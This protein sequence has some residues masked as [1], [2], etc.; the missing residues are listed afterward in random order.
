MV[1][2]AD[3]FTGFNE[4]VSAQL[5]SVVKLYYP[6][7]REECANCTLDTFGSV[8]RSVSI[9]KLGGPMPFDDG[10]PCP[11]CD[12][13]GYKQVEQ[14][15][16]IKGRIYSINKNFNNKSNIN[17]ADGDITLITR[18]EY[19]PNILRAKY[20]V[21]IQGMESLVLERYYLSGQPEVTGFKIN[22]V[23]YVTSRW[24]KLKDG[25]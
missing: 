9:Y 3:Y 8:S 24:N 21:P 17:I 4:L 15:E 20:I 6:E 1:S 2:Y 16:A 19:V 11:Y 5:E 12:G 10:M 14:S 25:V 22:P 23:R 13:K 7:K 18:I